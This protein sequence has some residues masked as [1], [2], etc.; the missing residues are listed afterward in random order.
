MAV[1]FPVVSFQ[2]FARV[3]MQV[4]MSLSSL[5]GTSS[6]VS[7]ESLRRSLKTILVYAEKDTD[8]QDTTFPEQVLCLCCF[9]FKRQD[10]HC[11]HEVSCSCHEL[12][13]FYCSL[14]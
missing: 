12:G 2:N 5:V 4:T 9:I 11:N 7:E 13:R 3:K 1:Y 8:L 14:Y 6:S 10:V